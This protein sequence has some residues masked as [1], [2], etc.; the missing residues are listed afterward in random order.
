MKNSSRLD[1]VSAND[2]TFEKRVQ[3]KRAAK[4]LKY[5]VA[6]TVADLGGEWSATNT[7]A[8]LSCQVDDV[9]ATANVFKKDNGKYGYKLTIDSSGI[10]DG[11]NIDTPHACVENILVGID[12]IAKTCSELYREA[13]LRNR[14]EQNESAS[15]D[16]VQRQLDDAANE[17][18]EES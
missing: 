8:E 15:D 14:E 12:S 3:E 5:R 11:A 10:G 18:I 2:I 4:N 1:V 17:G 9:S 13:Y 6:E 7:G 16:S